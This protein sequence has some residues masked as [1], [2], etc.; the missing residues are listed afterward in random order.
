M[1]L[2]FIRASAFKQSEAHRHPEPLHI[3]LLPAERQKAVGLQT[4]KGTKQ[5]FASE[6]AC[7][8]FGFRTC[9]YNL[10][11]IPFHA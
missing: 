8:Q 11:F 9:Y 1:L 5:G 7:S 4:L 2:L 10:E 6:L 3:F